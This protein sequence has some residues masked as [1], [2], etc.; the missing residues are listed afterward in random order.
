MMC[1][2]ELKE[3]VTPA[4]IREIIQA[5]DPEGRGVITREAFIAFNKKGKFD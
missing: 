1:A 4:E 2:D 3:E 5:C